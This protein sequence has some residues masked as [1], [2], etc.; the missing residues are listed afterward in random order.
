MKLISKRPKKGFT[1]VELLVVI[2]IIAVLAG[3]SSPAVLNALKNAKKVATKQTCVEV[4][5]G[6]EQY[7][8]DIGRL[9]NAPAAPTATADSA[10][11]AINDTTSIPSFL[12][13]LTKDNSRGF[14]Y[15]NM[16]QA[17]SSTSEGAQYDETSGDLTNVTDS[18]G[19][20]L[21][22]IFDNNYDNEIKIPVGIKAAATTLRGVNIVCYSIGAD[23]T[24]TTPKDSADNVL[25]WE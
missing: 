10:P 7:Y 5:R 1:L 19:N 25:S 15:L 18:W 16:K 3:L 12:L 9:P 2:A 20:P 21:Q 13:E 23:G 4:V 22:I 8:A 6:I 14:N 17:K 24:N 11:F